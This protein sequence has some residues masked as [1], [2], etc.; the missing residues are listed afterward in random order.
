MSGWLYMMQVSN[1]KGPPALLE[2][3]GLGICRQDIHTTVLASDLHASRAFLVY[4]L[5]PVE[6]TTT[7]FISLQ[8]P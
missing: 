2:A 3:E 1:A 8:V 5:D 7:S 4:V 6:E